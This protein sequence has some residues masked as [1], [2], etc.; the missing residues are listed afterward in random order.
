MTV[1]E[2]LDQIER[3]IDRILNTFGLREALSMEE[4]HKVE[5]MKRISRDAPERWR[6]SERGVGSSGRPFLF[7]VFE[8]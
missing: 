2:R 6:L 8:E 5:V 4:R 7:L 1:A 3:K